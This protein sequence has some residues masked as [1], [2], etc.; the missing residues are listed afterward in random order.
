VNDMLRRNTWTDL[1]TALGIIAIGAT[2]VLGALSHNA[3]V[4]F[5]SVA[6]LPFDSDEPSNGYLDDGLTMDIWMMD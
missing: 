2:F 3:D 5:S 1:I 4:P 6:A